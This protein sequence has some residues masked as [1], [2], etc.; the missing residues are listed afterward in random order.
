MEMRLRPIPIDF[1][2]GRK[3]SFFLE[4]FLLPLPP[5]YLALS[6]G[7]ANPPP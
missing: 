1:I 7:A 6:E 4:R 5:L 3:P 2:F